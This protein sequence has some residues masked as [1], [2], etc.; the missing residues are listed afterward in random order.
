VYFSRASFKRRRRVEAIER[1]PRHPWFR[2]ALREIFAAIVGGGR[3]ASNGADGTAGP[4]KCAE[5]V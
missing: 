3:D 1:L 5:Y 2:I 4:S